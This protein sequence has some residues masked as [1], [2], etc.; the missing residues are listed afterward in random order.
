MA[1]QRRGPDARA[2]I[3]GTAVGQ[4]KKRRLLVVARR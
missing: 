1:L 4:E 2:A 3:A